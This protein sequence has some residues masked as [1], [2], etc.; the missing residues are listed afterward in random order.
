MTCRKMV[1]MNIYAGRNR[2]ADI[3]NRFVDI[4][5]EGEGATN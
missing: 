1:L 5:L 2:E 3:E 4:T